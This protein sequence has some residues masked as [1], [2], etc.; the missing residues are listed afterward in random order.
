LPVPADEVRWVPVPADE[1]R[2]VRLRRP[3]R[4]SPG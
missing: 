4:L 3:I 2:W 1:V